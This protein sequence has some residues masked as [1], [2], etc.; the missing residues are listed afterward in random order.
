M[1]SYIDLEGSCRYNVRM[2][3]YL[4]WLILIDSCEDLGLAYVVDTHCEI[5]ARRQDK[6]RAWSTR[7]PCYIEDVLLEL[8]SP[9]LSVRFRA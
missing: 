1:N 4:D 2:L 7:A 3:K 8:M 5:L 6:V 9:I